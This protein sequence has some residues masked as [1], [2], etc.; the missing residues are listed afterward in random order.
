MKLGVPTYAA[1]DKEGNILYHWESDFI[2]YDDAQ[3]LSDD[4]DLFFRDKEIT[5]VRIIPVFISQAG[6]PVM[7]WDKE[8]ADERRRKRKEAE[9]VRKQEWEKYKADYYALHPEEA[10]K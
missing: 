3:L 8:S 6:E 10:L 4:L 2:G 7:I 9:K 1:V 5:E